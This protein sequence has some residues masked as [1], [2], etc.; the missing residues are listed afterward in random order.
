LSW[1][2]QPV[3]DQLIGLFAAL[4]AD[5]K[6]G[7]RMVAI[8]VIG[9]LAKTGDVGLLGLVLL[10]ETVLALAE[11]IEQV[12]VSGFEGERGLE[13]LAGLLVRPALK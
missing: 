5:V 6:D 9:G 11:I 8:G 10:A 4:A 7:Q 12:G 2:A 3:I 1:L 13:R